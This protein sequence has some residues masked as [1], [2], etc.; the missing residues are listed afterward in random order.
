MQ[1]VPAR[2]GRRGRRAVRRS[3]R[4]N[5]AERPRDR[6][7]QCGRARARSASGLSTTAT[8]RRRTRARRSSSRSRS[9][10][11]RAATRRS[12]RRRSPARRVSSAL[13][14]FAR[15]VPAAASATVHPL[16]IR[17]NRAKARAHGAATDVPRDGG[18]GSRDRS[19]KPLCRSSTRKSRSCL[20]MRRGHRHGKSAEKLTIPRRNA[21][22]AKRVQ[23]H[24]GCCG[25]S[26]AVVDPRR[27]G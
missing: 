21:D 27:G 16:P 5:C 26:R 13:R 9:G 20:L 12:P 15:R 24:G 17:W 10:R 2:A 4:V 3:P 19:A 23:R 14:T 8:R 22:C 18:A 11:A 25:H 7:R 1:V 6:R